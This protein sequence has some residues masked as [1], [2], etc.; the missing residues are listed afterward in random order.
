VTSLWKRE[1]EQTGKNTDYFG[2]EVRLDYD[3][4]GGQESYKEDQG[5]INTV[6]QGDKLGSRK[7]KTHICK[8]RKIETQSKEKKKVENPPNWVQK[9]HRCAGGRDTGG[10]G[11]PLVEET[12]QR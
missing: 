11:A 8:D 4:F 2:G 7:G 3:M 9:G 10:K 5:H 12:M 1:T 6:S